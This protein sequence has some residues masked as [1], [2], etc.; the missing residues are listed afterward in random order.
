MA[1][2]QRLRHAT[3]TLFK[4][5]VKDPEIEAELRPILS[6][7]TKERNSGERFGDWCDRVILKEQPAAAN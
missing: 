2:R 5:V 1:R 7:Y 6:R 3:N 4:E